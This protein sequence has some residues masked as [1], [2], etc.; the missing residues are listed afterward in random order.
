MEQKTLSNWLKAAIVCLAL[1]GLFVYGSVV[2][3]YGQLLAAQNPEY[4]HC[5][6]PWMTL[7]ILTAIPCYT[8]LVF[9]WQIASDIGRDKSFRQLQ[10]MV[11]WPPHDPEHSP[12][13]RPRCRAR[14]GRH[15]TP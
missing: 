3:S 13:H 4:A 8:S 9:G 1:F 5:F 11:R 14:H 10:R 2:P 15:H 6:W 7:L 12:K